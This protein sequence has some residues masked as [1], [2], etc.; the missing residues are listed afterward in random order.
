MSPEKVQLLILWTGLLSCVIIAYVGLII[1][2]ITGEGEKG[3]EDRYD[4]H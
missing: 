1:L 4:N 3:P 2:T